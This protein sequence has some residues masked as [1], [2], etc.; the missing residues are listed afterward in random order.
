MKRFVLRHERNTL[1]EREREKERGR[2]RERER[3]RALQGWDG[4]ELMTVVEWCVLG[5]KD[6]RCIGREFH[7][8]GEELGMI[9]QQ[10]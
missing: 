3:E 7:M 1:R 10:T 9:D 5:A 6:R 8:R 4:V 2:E